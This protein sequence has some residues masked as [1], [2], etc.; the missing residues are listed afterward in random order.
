MRIYPL[1]DSALTVELST[2][3]S[4]ETNDIIHALAHLLDEARVRRLVQGVVE[5]VPAFTTLT[6]LYNPLE[7]SIAALTRIIEDLTTEA[8]EIVLHHEEDAPRVVRIPVCFA[9]EFA[10]DAAELALQCGLQV[11]EMARVVTEG[12]YRVAMVGFTPGFPYLL[13]LDERLHAPRKAMPRTRVPAGSV[14][15]GGAQ[16]GMYPLETP[17]GWNIIGRTPLRLFTPSAEEPC[18]LRAGDAVQF[19]S[20]SREEFTAMMG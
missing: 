6:V 1:G 12:E 18:L 17:G 3:L 16:L 9:E 4:R 13:G 11:G 7:I 19:T 5:C 8:T 10:L 15:I 2:S 20:I 14:A